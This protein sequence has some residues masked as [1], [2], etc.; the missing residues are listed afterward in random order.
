MRFRVAGKQFLLM[1]T[2]YDTKYWRKKFKYF[3][4]RGG[5]GA[6]KGLPRP[7]YNAFTVAQIT[8]P[9]FTA[10]FKNQISIT[11]H[12]RRRFD[13]KTKKAKTVKVSGGQ[14]YY[15]HASEERAYERTIDRLI[16]DDTLVPAT[17]A[18]NQTF[19][20]EKKLEQKNR[21]KTLAYF[22]FCFS[23]IF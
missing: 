5:R 22:L 2:N 18:D 16:A 20:L 13:F 12:C 6:R 7:A 9:H 8:F 21:G 11:N 10:V 3:K 23:Q 19:L 4:R 1:G 14:N 15:S 17:N